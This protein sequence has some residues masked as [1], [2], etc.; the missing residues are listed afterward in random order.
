MQA[1]VTA[2]YTW[3][4]FMNKPYIGLSLIG[5]RN[6]KNIGFFLLDAQ[7]GAHI[8]NSL[9]QGVL[10]MSLTYLTNI[11][12][13]ERYRFRYLGKLIYTTGI[14]RFTNDMLYLGESYG[15]VGIKNKAWSA[16][17]IC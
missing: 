14:N 13:K 2:G 10:N 17:V 12:K 7:F 5:S 16:K 1:M 9:D 15:F 4:E 8:S 11:Y 6:L 3:S